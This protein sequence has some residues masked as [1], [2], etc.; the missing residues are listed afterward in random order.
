MLAYLLVPV[1]VYCCLGYEFEGLELELFDPEPNH[2]DPEDL[3]PQPPELEDLEPP[4]LD[5]PERPALD[6]WIKN[7]PIKTRQISVM[8]F[9]AFH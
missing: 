1:L 3:L 9:M 2:D 6:S 4:P 5:P 7:D 8:F